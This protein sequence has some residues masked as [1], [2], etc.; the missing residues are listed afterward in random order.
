MPTAHKTRTTGRALKS[1]LPA[2]IRGWFR[3][4]LQDNHAWQYV[5]AEPFHW[6]FLCFF[7]PIR[8][9]HEVDRTGIFRRFWGMLRLALPVF[10]L[11]ALLALLVR[12]GL[13]LI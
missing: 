13:P 9:S 10:V 3:T 4:L 5:I 1:G 2:S 12:W 11:A 8:F 6:L 7:Q